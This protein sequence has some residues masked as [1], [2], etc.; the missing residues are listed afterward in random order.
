MNKA[1]FIKS[2]E[3]VTAE[4]LAAEPWSLCTV[5]QVEELKALIRVLPIW[6]TAIMI[7]VTI[8]Q[9]QVPVLQAITMDRHLISNFSI[10]AGSFI[11]FGIL[12]LTIWVTI[13]D[14]L[15][16]PIVSKYTKNP[17]GLNFKQRMGIGLG[18]SCLATTVA[19]LV[20]RNRRKIAITEGF[21]N[22]SLGV[23]SMSAMWLIPQYCL[24]GLA[25]AFNAIGQIEFYYSQ[26]PKS[27]TSIGMALFALGMGLGSLI[28]SLI[29]GI[30][31]VVT[32]KGG[33]VSWVT[34]NLNMGHY[35]YYYW[36]LTV[37]SVVN[38]LYYL[39]CSWAYGSC[40]NI[41]IWEEGDGTKEEDVPKSIGSP[42]MFSQ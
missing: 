11:V 24:T 25:E 2:P 1:C 9:Q 20:E 27:M 42:V 21:S 10:P 8:S 23:V 32:Q 29:I 12:T 34:N 18:L 26:F 37:L 22:N 15:V 19:A 38:F 5:K 3:D 40:D 14:R 7:G 30:V 31:N 17:R 16:V 4:G 39:I 41:K 33:Q 36:L 13:Y 6:S 35:D 28:G